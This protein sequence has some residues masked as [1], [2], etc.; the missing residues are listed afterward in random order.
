LHQLELFP[1][2]TDLFYPETTETGQQ[3]TELGSHANAGTVQRIGSLVT[4]ANP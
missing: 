3:M 1:N 4:N 2:K